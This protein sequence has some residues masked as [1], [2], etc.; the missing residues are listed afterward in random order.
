ML[1]QKKKKLFLLY[2]QK[3]IFNIFFSFSTG[4]FPCVWL[5]KFLFDV[6]MKYKFNRES[7]TQVPIE[8]KHKRGL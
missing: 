8:N 1:F 7:D 3:D 4:Y 6:F 2:E 5:N